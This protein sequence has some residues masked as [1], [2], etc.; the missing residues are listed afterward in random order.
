MFFELLRCVQLLLLLRLRLEPELT[1]IEEPV[2]AERALPR[3]GPRSPFGGG[4]GER[5][6]SRM[7]WSPGL[8]SRAGDRDTDLDG[9]R[10]R[11]RRGGDIERSG[12]RDKSRLSGGC[13]GGEPETP[14]T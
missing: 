10:R 1:D 6:T 11:S 14:R 5:V 7:L 9:D 13:G 3:R 4:E 2:E 12:R 8:S